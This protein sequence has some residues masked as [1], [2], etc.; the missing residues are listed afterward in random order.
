MYVWRLKLAWKANAQ[1][2]LQLDQRPRGFAD[3]AADPVLELTT[4][5]TDISAKT[6]IPL[7]VHAADN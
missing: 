2:E 5:G 3:L 4:I 7:Q 1:E 6:G